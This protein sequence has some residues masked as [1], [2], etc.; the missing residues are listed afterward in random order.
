[1]KRQIEDVAF[2]LARKIL[3]ESAPTHRVKTLQYSTLNSIFLQGKCH[4]IAKGAVRVI[5]NGFV[6][7]IEAPFLHCS[8]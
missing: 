2:W 5:Q 8:N 1:M 3:N 7:P 6:P 4:S